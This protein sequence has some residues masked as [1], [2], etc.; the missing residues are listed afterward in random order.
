MSL[1]AA[2][3]AGLGARLKDIGAPVGES[4]GDAWDPYPGGGAGKSAAAPAKTAA[5]AAAG[6]K[7]KALK[8]DPAAAAARAPQP[9][10]VNR[11]VARPAPAKAAAPAPQPAARPRKPSAWLQDEAGGTRVNP[12]QYAREL[13]R[14]MNEQ[15]RQVTRQTVLEVNAAEIEGVAEMAARIRGRYFAKLLDAGGP[16]QG[17]LQEAELAELKH[18]RE[19]YHELTEGFAMLRDAIEAG[20]ISVS[21]MVGGPKR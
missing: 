10:N 7:P 15:N 6:L 12:Q 19:M 17:F 3:K 2:L 16:R 9:A 18:Y 8:L 4:A 14:F 5:P 11:A 13:D 21:G 20:D 1:T